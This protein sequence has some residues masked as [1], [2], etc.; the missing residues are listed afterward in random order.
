[1]L[2]VTRFAHSLTT[3]MLRDGPG[4]HRSRV[5]LVVDKHAVPLGLSAQDV[6]EIAEGAITEAR[7]LFARLKVPLKDV[8]VLDK[9]RVSQ[10]LGKGEPARPASSSD[11]SGPQLFARLEGEVEALLRAEAGGVASVVTLVLRAMQEG[12]GFDR[13][14]FGLV[15]PD[16]T[17]VQ[18]R[19]ALG[20]GADGFKESFSIPI[21]KT[22]GPMGV[23]LARQQDLLLRADWDLRPDEE[24]QM[25]QLGVCVLGLLPMTW[26]GTLLGCLY[27]DRGA[28]I[29][30]TTPE[31]EAGLRRLRDRCVQMLS[32]SK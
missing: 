20:V 6:E 27:Y 2:K 23:A 10:A 7:Q 22:G 17:A 29:G 24:Q 11:V 31:L 5:A 30:T 28:T 3:A 15:S 32:R 14:L 18:G 1:M 26:R 21:G 4:D 25:K 19:L 13:V 8:A 12:A 16:R 9:R